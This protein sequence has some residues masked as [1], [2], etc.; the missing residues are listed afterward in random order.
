MKQFDGNS[1]YPHTKIIESLQLCR[2]IS[3]IIVLFYHEYLFLNTYMPG[4]FPDWFQIAF[5][6]GNYGVDFF[7]VLSG[8]IILNAHYQDQDNTASFKRYALRRLIRIFPAYLPLSIFS[9]ISYYVDVYILEVHRG[10]ISIISSLFLVPSFHRPAL[11]VAW[12]LIHEMIFYTIFSMFFFWRKAFPAFIALWALVLMANVVFSWELTA[13]PLLFPIVS[14][15]NLEFI[16]GMICAAV[17]RRMHISGTMGVVLILAGIAALAAILES[18][19]IPGFRQRCILTIPFALITLGMCALEKGTTVTMPRAVLLLGDASYSLYLI[20]VPLLSALFWAVPAVNRH[21]A[22][23]GPG[24]EWAVT[25]ALGAGISIIA[26]ILY[27]KFY[28]RPALN[29]LRGKA[30]PPKPAGETGLITA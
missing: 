15:I 5:K 26:G 30:L 2:A 19:S 22:A 11:G 18:N 27:H 17:W 23:A 4:K 8:F 3:A 24:V 13:N 6:S 10:E 21:V 20:H 16:G 28:E 7:F 12:T 9:I 14:T 1:F 25:A 29:F